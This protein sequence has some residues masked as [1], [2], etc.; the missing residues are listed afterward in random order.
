LRRQTRP[1]KVGSK[2]IGGAAPVS[3]QSMT[4]TVTRDR[5]STMQQ[6]FRLHEAGCELVRLAV[7]DE[8]SAKTLSYYKH[9]SPIPVIADIH[10]DY[11]LALLSIEHGADKIRINPGNIGGED[12][13]G[14]V[15]NKASEANVAI[16]VGVNAGS[17][18]KEMVKKHGGVTADTLVESALNCLDLMEKLQFYN[19]V[20]SLKASDVA[21]NVQAY[22][23]IAEFTSYPLHLGVTEA[24]RGYRAAVKSALGIGSLLLKGIGDTVRVSVTGDPVQEVFLAKD[25][26]QAAGVRAFGPEI[27]SCPTCARC[28]VDLEALVEQVEVATKDVREPLKIAVMGCPV[29]G[30]GEAR[31]ADLGISGTG[32]KGGVVFKKGKIVKHAV[33]GDLLQI[34]KEELD[35]IIT[36]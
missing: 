15:I 29:N 31:E 28:Q 3:I 14:Q 21:T 4:N 18:S 35:K 9:N 22:E 7:P 30:P 33:A 25:I 32:G 13:L 27:I 16:R 2:T 17:V 10:F 1:V 11:R 19:I 12:R 20:I 24:G 23:R 36:Q 26:L 8:A 34:F 6:I 5:D